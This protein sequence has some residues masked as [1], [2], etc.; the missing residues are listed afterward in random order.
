MSQDHKA[1]LQSVKAAIAYLSQDNPFLAHDELQKAIRNL[2][3][4]CDDLRCQL[5]DVFESLT[6]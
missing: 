1:T 2:Q 4:D 3:D 6:R 5:V